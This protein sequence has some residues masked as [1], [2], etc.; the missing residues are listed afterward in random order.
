MDEVGFGSG[1]KAKF[2]S[3]MKNVECMIVGIRIVIIQ[4][5]M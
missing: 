5:E 4:M 3:I 2:I 1:L